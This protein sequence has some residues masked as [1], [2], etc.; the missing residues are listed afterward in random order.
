MDTS[1]KDSYGIP[2][3]A[4]NAKSSDE[5]KSDTIVLTVP[6]PVDQSL[7]ELG[8]KM[9]NAAE[10]HTSALTD[11][12]RSTKYR[13]S[14]DTS[15]YANG[16]LSIL[17]RIGKLV[18]AKNTTEANQSAFKLD[19]GSSE[20]YSSLR[21]TTLGSLNIDT[22]DGYTANPVSNTMPSTNFS[23][24]K[25]WI[26]KLFPTLSNN[27]LMMVT[28]LEIVQALLFKALANKGGS[29]SAPNK[30]RKDMAQIIIDNQ[31][32]EDRLFNETGIN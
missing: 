2:G 1:T 20:F 14:T 24:N 9:I 8:Y 18:F 3:A 12:H 30:V 15:Y 29:S 19:Q 7:K 28:V 27:H 22:V 10:W 5:L 31:T 23:P 4:I 26:K 25:P 17:D 13:A 32:I 16:S 6:Q 21:T 11:E